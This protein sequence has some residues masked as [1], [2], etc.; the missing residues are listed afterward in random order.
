MKLLGM[1]ATRLEPGIDTVPDWVAADP[2][3]KSLPQLSGISNRVYWDDAG[4]GQL[5]IMQ[6]E[7]PSGRVFCALYEPKTCAELGLEYGD[8]TDVF[9]LAEQS[10]KPG[11]SG[12]A[13]K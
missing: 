8:L 12:K 10:G 4:R 9:R 2:I 13:A 6:R 3:V 5:L 7:D 1:T 11:K